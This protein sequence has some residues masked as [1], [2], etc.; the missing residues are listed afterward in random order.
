MY[1]TY[2]KHVFRGETRG[3]CDPFLKRILKEQGNAYCVGVGTED[4]NPLNFPVYN[5]PNGFMP[6]I[7]K[8]TMTTEFIIYGPLR[9]RGYG[10]AI[11]GT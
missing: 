10:H 6:G 7:T 8:P 1:R 5:F 4:G 3:Y 2:F 11:T 9:S